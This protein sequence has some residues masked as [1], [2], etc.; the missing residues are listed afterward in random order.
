MQDAEYRA[1]A[2]YSRTSY[3]AGKMRA[4]GY[5][6]LEADRIADETFTRLLPLGRNSRDHYFYILELAGRKLGSLWFALQ[7]P[8]ENRK[9]FV[10]DVL[11][12]ENERGKGY[13]RTVME[14]A[15]LEGGRLGAVAIG[16]HVFAFNTPAVKLYESLAYQV[17]DLS[18]EKR[19]SR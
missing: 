14:L 6:E 13:G 3:A 9:A 18:M 5:S 8:P 2:E 16:L 11:I 15:E 1:W 17:T 7:G 19:I 4:N 12:D 10:Y